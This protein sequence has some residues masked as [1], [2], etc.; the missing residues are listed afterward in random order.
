MK[1]LAIDTETTLIPPPVLG[2]KGRTRLSPFIVPDLVCASYA[3]SDDTSGV[4]VR[5]DLPHLLDMLTEGLTNGTELVFHNFAFDFFVLIKADPRFRP[6]L[7]TYVDRCAVHDT[8]VL[9]TLLQIARGS[10]VH[11]DKILRSRSLQYLAESRCGRILPKD[12][13]VRLHFGDYLGREHALPQVFR[14]YAEQDAVATL[15][16]YRA[17]LPEVRLYASTATRY[18]VFPDAA[19]KF[20]LLG[21]SVHVKGAVALMW[22][23]QFPLRVDVPRAQEFLA[24]YNGERAH[25]EYALLAFKWARRAPKSSKFSLNLKGIRAVLKSWAADNG[26]VPPLSDT[27]LVTTE[28]D[29]WKEHLT[30]F[31][32]DPATAHTLTDTAARLGVFLRFQAVIKQLGFL[33]VYAA[34]PEHYP[35]YFNIGARTGRTSASRPNVQQIPKSRDSLRSLFIPRPGH[36]IAECDF[37][38]AELVALAQ[39]YKLAYGGSALGDALNAGI[40]PHAAAAERL[41]GPTDY[42]KLDDAERK[43]AR[44]MAKALNFGQPGGL[45]AAKF[46]GY[47]KRLTGIVIDE[48]TARGMLR[49]NRTADPALNAYL[50]D[51]DPESKLRLAADNLGLSFEQLIEALGAYTED[52]DISG[53]L[54]TSNLRAWANGDP[55]AAPNL[56]APPGFDAGYDLFK[57]TTAAPYGLIR[58]RAA[59]CPSHNTP[60]QASTAAAQKIALYNLWRLW[61]PSSPWQPIVQV[62]DSI[63]IDHPPDLDCAFLKNAM[64]AA[65]QVLYPDIR[66]GADLT[67]NLE[68]WGE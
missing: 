50:S 28:R 61:T 45:G 30:A 60:Y 41:Y 3:T 42:A 6:L 31:S 66:A 20:G 35:S 37:A 39:V 21:E 44:K 22:L 48:P 65:T 2:A 10:S 29:Y 40:D 9:E 15:A 47:L 56:L 38:A 14:D 64:L 54:A 68:R 8:M 62:H 51:R 24:R 27:G 55:S 57:E 36:R 46:C 7:E 58:G 52:G 49:A 25:L 16:V 23:E 33:E 18:P 4:V 53:R 11:T 5:P 26:I 19:A 32:G 1:L 63:A 43:T 17:Q 13:V 12:D 67:T 34:G 59:F